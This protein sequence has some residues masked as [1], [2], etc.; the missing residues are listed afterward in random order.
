MSENQKYLYEIRKSFITETEKNFIREIINC[1]PPGYYIQPQVNL[2]SIIARTDNA[3]YH[4]ELFRNVDACIFD[5]N[6]HPV[7]IIEINDSTHTYRKR[8]ERD[9]KV[10]NICEE[11]GLPIIILW[12]SYGLNNEYIK[13]RISKAIEESKNPVRIAHSQMKDQKEKGFDLLVVKNEQEAEEP[14]SDNPVPSFS[15]TS[16]QAEK[17]KKKKGC[18]IATAVYGDYNCPQVCTLRKFRDEYL[19]N[20]MV[21]RIFIFFY[22]LISP[23]IIRKFGGK[24]SFNDF[25]RKILDKLVNYLYCK[26]YFCS[27]YTDT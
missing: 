11:A 12:T 14:V 23:Q 4:N 27:S 2:A 5:I 20:H 3:R 15:S 1:L 19:S 25:W 8:A 21:G 18:Y 17:S 16:T 10:K 13:K 6:Y 26:N 7:A 24:E 22:Y 9:K